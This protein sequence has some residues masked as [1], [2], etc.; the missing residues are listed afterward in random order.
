MNGTTI[1]RILIHISSLLTVSLHI[2]F[3]LCLLTCFTATTERDIRLQLVRE[4]EADAARGDL[5]PHQ[6]TPSIFLTTGL[7][8]EE[9]Q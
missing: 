2:D 7:D 6:I 4:E 8:L 3:S 1:M 9:H 5:S